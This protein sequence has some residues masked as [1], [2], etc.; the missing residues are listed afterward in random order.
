M[1]K[2]LFLLSKAENKR[3]V[4]TEAFILAVRDNLEKLL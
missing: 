4:D 1:T 3:A 2:D